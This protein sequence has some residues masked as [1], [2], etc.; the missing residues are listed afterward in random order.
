MM[1]HRMMDDD[2]KTESADISDPIGDMGA[3]QLGYIFD[4]MFGKKDEDKERS[5]CNEHDTL[6]DYQNNSA[7]ANK[8]N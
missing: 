1:L 3:S 6:N 7:D 4:P 8:A 2:D 5:E